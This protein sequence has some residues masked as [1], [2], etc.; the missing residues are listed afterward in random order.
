MTSV[1]RITPHAPCTAPRGSDERLAWYHARAEAG[2]PIWDDRDSLAIIPPQ[3][4][5]PD[6]SSDI[7]LKVQRDRFGVSAGD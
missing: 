2:L 5:G 7:E 4:N 6:R 3:W 1:S